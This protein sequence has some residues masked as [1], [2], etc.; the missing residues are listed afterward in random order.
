ML[1]DP[2]VMAV[3]PLMI[4]ARRRRLE[5]RQR[6]LN[7]LERSQLVV[8]GAKSVHKGPVCGAGWLLRP[9]REIPIEMV[10][11]RAWLRQDEG[12]DIPGVL[13]RQRRLPPHRPVGHV[14]ANEVGGVDQSVH[15]GAIVEAVI[16]PERRCTVAL[17]IADV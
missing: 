8:P 16:A 12:R 15:T 6:I 4:V 3:S 2:I 13:A 7:W 10:L 1:P 11:V 5:R 14:G 17:R 9:D